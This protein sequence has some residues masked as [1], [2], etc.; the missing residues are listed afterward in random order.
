MT[1]H[2]SSALLKLSVI[3]FLF[4]LFVS[5]PAFLRAKPTVD[6]NPI[7]FVHGYGGSGSSFATLQ[8]YLIDQGWNKDDLYAVNFTD[9]FG[10]NVRNAAELSYHIEMVKKRTGKS[11]IDLIAHSMGGLSVRYYLEHMNTHD[12]I[13][14]VITLGS[15]HH[16]IPGDRF[17]GT[18]G[19]NEMAPTSTFLAQLN[20]ND[21]TPGG[22]N[23]DHIIRYTSIYSKGDK[24][25]PYLSSPLK[26]ANN[27]QVSKP[28]HVGI[29]SDSLVMS[30]VA[31]ALR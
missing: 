14:H 29:L 12:S 21:E 27:I 1:T 8:S 10:S 18:D 31:E 6:K 26:G 3:L 24:V 17:K 19:G 30:Y 9:H 20:K 5:N 7:I 2:P 11:K 23:R 16:G 15:P 22:S 4:L 25:V 28:S 13:D